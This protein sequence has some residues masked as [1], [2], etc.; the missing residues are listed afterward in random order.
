MGL[1][2]GKINFLVSQAK[3]L[4]MLQCSVLQKRR[5]ADGLP[6]SPADWHDFLLS[7]QLFGLRMCKPSNR[8]A[9]ST[10]MYAL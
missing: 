5:A 3:K 2:R 7:N 4:L 1:S 8:Q 6:L 10:D 9:L